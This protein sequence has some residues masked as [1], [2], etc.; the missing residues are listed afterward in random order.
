MRALNRSE[1]LGR[2]KAGDSLQDFNATSA[3]RDE[4]ALLSD[5]FMVSGVAITSLS[6]YFDFDQLNPPIQKS[7]VTLSFAPNGPR[8]KEHSN[9]V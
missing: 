1:E 6:L 9:E 3:Q 2:Y 4:A 7:T 5:L 8:S